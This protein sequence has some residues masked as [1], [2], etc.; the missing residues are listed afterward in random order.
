MNGGESRNNSLIP[1]ENDDNFYNIY[2]HKPPSNQKLN[3]LLKKSYDFE[4]NNSFNSFKKDEAISVKSKKRKNN[5]KRK[6]GNKKAIF[7]Y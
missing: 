6:N 2:H 5:E 1:I 7:Y 3:I 4:K